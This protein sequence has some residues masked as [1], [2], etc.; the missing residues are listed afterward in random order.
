MSILN[1]SGDPES[2]GTTTKSRP[3]VST[4]GTS[5][6]GQGRR[7]EGREGNNAG[8]ERWG[9]EPVRAMRSGV[10]QVSDRVRDGFESARDEMAREYRSAEGMI[11]RNPASS[12]IL[13]FGVGFGLGILLTTV[14]MP[15][16]ETWAERYLPDSLRDFRM[17]DRYR[18]A[19]AAQQVPDSLQSSFHQLAESIR[20]L[21]SSI[22]RLMPHH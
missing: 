3:G 11:A 19:R 9:N 14:L 2:S 5:N 6:Q 20:D 21:P 10:E 17:P 15:R 1:G 12:V 8:P 4:M 16:E 18:M 7:K 22:A 13:G